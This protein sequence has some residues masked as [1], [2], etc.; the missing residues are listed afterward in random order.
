MLAERVSASPARW[1]DGGRDRARDEERASRAIGAAYSAVFGPDPVDD[2]VVGHEPLHLPF[3]AGRYKGEVFV[4]GKIAIRFVVS[5]TGGS[6]SDVPVE[7]VRYVG[8]LRR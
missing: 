5:L 6:M 4:D 8:R 2:G 7:E 1:R 3:C